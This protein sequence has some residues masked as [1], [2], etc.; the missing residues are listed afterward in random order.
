MSNTLSKLG[1]SAASRPPGTR[2]PEDIRQRI[3]KAI[4]LSDDARD[5]ARDHLRR[6]PSY[7]IDDEE[8]TAR[9]DVPALPSLHVHMHSEPDIK[10]PSEPPIRKQLTAGI[11]ALGSGIGVALLT[12]I[13]ALAQ[14]CGHR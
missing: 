9:H 1:K 14:S 7:D 6:L 10:K 3:A 12:G 11:I 4:E 5:I 8:S 2:P 13:A